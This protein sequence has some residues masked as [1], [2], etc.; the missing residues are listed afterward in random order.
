MLKAFTYKPKKSVN[1]RGIF[2]ATI[3]RR[4]RPLTDTIKYGNVL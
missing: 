3:S 4:S 2:T 1:V